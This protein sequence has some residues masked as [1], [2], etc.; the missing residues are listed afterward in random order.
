MRT[1]KFEL[2][3]KKKKKQ[4]ARNITDT[5]ICPLKE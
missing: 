4:E 2:K 3:K 1:I 5:R